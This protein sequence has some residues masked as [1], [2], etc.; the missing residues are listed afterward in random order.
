[1]RQYDEEKYCREC[2]KELIRG[3]KRIY[4]YGKHNPVTGKPSLTDI[5]VCPEVYDVKYVKDGWF[6]K[7][8]VRFFNELSR[9][10]INYDL[11]A[12]GL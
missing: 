12:I 5:M 2:G 8:P 9:H 1:M 3:G 7:K 11:D 4:P 6:N 10:T